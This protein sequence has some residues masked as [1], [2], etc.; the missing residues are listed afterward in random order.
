MLPDTLHAPRTLP[1]RT[2][3]SGG[4][5]WICRLLISKHTHTP[6]AKKVEIKADDEGQDDFS[7]LRLPFRDVRNRRGELDLPNELAAV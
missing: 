1:S 6:S 5:I 3:G 7:D 4:Q 2:V